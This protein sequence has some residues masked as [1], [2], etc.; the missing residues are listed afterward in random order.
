MH[1]DRRYNFQAI[2]NISGKVPEILNIRTIHNPTGEPSIPVREFNL[3]ACW[4]AYS[5]RKPLFQIL[6]ST[7]AGKS[8]QPINV[9][10]TVAY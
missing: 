4:L 8:S 1:Y 9:A 10:G 3:I 2:A 7:Q 6:S 5:S